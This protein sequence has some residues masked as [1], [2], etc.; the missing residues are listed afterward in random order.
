MQRVTVSSTHQRLQYL[1]S[2]DSVRMTAPGAASASSGR[3]VQLEEMNQLQSFLEVLMTL[4]LG[5]TVVVPQSYAFDSWAFLSVAERV[6]VARGPSTTSAD[7]P[8]RLHLFGAG[9]ESFDDAVRSMLARV[10]DP[11]RPFVS[12]LLPGLSELDPQR[13][14]RMSDDLESLLGWADDRVSPS[15]GRVMGEFRHLQ[16]VQAR[17]H[18]PVALGQ[19]LADLVDPASAMWQAASQMDEPSRE[20][21]ATLVESVRQLDPTRPASFA[22]R[23]G[24]RHGAPWPGD[25]EGRP[26]REI[27]GGEQLA[28]VTEFVDTLYNRVVAD[29]IGVAPSTFSTSVA[30][31]EDL[32]RARMVAQRLALGTSRSGD[33]SEPAQDEIPL[34]EVRL[35]PEALRDNA[36]VSAEAKRL[37]TLGSGELRPLLDARS[38][39]GHGNRRSPFWE[40]VDRLDRAVLEG[41]EREMNRALDA[42]LKHVTGLLGGRAE[43]G[44]G[45]RRQVQL[46]LMTAAGAGLPSIAAST[47]GIPVVAGLTAVGAVAPGIAE[48][49]PSEIRRRRESRRRASA[50]GEFV[51]VSPA[52]GRQ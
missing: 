15:L 8:F 7:R 22:Q 52:G 43:L 25:P 11:E 27:V 19:M 17:P 41:E 46:V 51:G 40:S 38:E 1:E 39:V 37:L 29:S 13:L 36:A 24:L 14:T 12:S 30:L 35:R 31:G 2:M 3:D 23:S 50:W 21:H 4:A 48:F 44:M 33:T 18:K 5:R 45:G 6:L 47:W 26:A 20:V 42:H 49:L 10:H 16:P 9:I 28:L 34:F 32:R